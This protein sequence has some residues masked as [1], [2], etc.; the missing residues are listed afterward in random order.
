M[1]SAGQHLPSRDTGIKTTCRKRERRC[2][3]LAART[4][5]SC[6]RRIQWFTQAAQ[7]NSHQ[8]N[9]KR[10]T[11]YIPEHYDVIPQHYL[12]CQ[13]TLIC[14]SHVCL[15]RTYF[16]GTQRFF[17]FFSELFSITS[18]VYSWSV[19]DIFKHNRAIEPSTMSI[20]GPAKAVL[21]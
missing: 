9:E 8:S 3:P 2:H 5:R 13:E 7:Q 10:G 19:H 14:P 15:F 20:T 11:A 6:T 4:L 17:F 1:T 12:P 18:E 16:L 21:D